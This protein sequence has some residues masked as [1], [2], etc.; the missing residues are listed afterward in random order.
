MKLEQ[1]TLD[2]KGNITNKT[3]FLNGEPFIIH[4]MHSAFRY[5]GKGSDDVGYM[6]IMSITTDGKVVMESHTAN[7]S[8]IGPSTFTAYAYVLGKKI[9]VCLRYDS[10]D[11]E[12][13]VEDKYFEEKEIE[14]IED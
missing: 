14:R 5:I 3:R 1:Y 12:T 2:K 6:I 7:V 11:F 10:L 13:K 4:L 8:K 9:K